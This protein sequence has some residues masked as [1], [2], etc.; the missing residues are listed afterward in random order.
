MPHK[1]KHIFD[2]GLTLLI[3]LITGCNRGVPLYEAT[4]EAAYSNGKKLPESIV[5]FRSVNDGDRHIS[6]GMVGADG[7][8]VMTTDELGEGVL[9]GEYKAVV[10]PRAHGGKH[11]VTMDA[12]PRKYRDYQTTP[13]KF[14]VTED[15]SKNHFRLEIEPPKILA[16]L[17]KK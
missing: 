3:L 12:V 15:E 7:K 9:A 16:K 6:S 10:I 1:H 4:G 8:F 13:L 2:Y 14:V 17:Q 11:P 5:E